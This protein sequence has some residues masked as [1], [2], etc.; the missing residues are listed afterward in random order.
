MCQIKN[1]ND[2]DSY[3]IFCRMFLVFCLDFRKGRTQYRNVKLDVIGKLAALQK[4]T[5]SYITTNKGNVRYSDTLIYSFRSVP[6]RE[7]IIMDEYGQRLRD[8]VGPF[9]EGAHLSL[10]CEAEG[11]NP[12]PTLVWLK[13]G[14]LLDDS[15]SVTPQGIIRNELV[16]TRLRR[17]DLMS[18]LTCQALNSNL[19]KPTIATI[20]L[21]LNC[22]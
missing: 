7:V 8:T 6:A 17:S 10:A 2:C 22:E 20:T 21:D 4:V 15:W 9:N 3:F 16:I 19:T 14:S 13:D 12:T 1:E 18:H 11:G 5:L